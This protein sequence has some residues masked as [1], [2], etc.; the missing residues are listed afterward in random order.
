[1]VAALQG[2][3]AANTL[4]YHIVKSGYGLWLPGDDRGSWSDAW[5]E[6][7]GYIEPHTLHDGDPVR[8]RMAEERMAHPPVH[9]TFD[10][11]DAVVAA[12][13]ECIGKSR[14]GLVVAAMS[15]EPTHMHLLIPYDGKHDIDNTAKWIADQTT[16]AVHRQTS[17]GGP[18]WCGGKW[19]SYLFDES[20]WRNAV[21]YIRRH[22]VRRGMAADPYPFIT[23][24][25]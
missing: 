3:P 5:D 13:G 7:I 6:Q 20:H 22:N 18:V 23:P 2:I 9:F 17:Y 25:V 8:K 16:K 4:G 11:I 24:T 12:L 10:M 14:G 21:D 19:R 1:L 15:I